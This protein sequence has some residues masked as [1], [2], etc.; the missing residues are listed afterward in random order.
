MNTTLGIIPEPPLVNRFTRGCNIVQEDSA[1]EVLDRIDALLRAVSGI[2]YTYFRFKFTIC[3][4]N[5]SCEINIYRNMG[6]FKQ[7]KITGWFSSEMIPDGGKPQFAIEYEDLT[8]YFSGLFSYIMNNYSAESPAT[9]SADDLNYGC[10]CPHYGHDEEEDE[11]ELQR[12]RDEQE[13]RE[14]QEEQEELFDRYYGRYTA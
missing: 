4:E 11:D 14:V 9:F 2:T 7:P 3:V 12:E 8:R 10:Y 5:K 13:K 6:E 1:Q